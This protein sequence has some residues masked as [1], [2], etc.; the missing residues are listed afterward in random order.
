[1]HKNK[2]KQ[3]NDKHQ[4]IIVFFVC[5]KTKQNKMT[6]NANWLSSSLGAKKQKKK[7][8]RQAQLVVI[9]SQ[10]T[11]KNNKDNN[12]HQGSSSFSVANEKKGDLGKKMY[13]H[14]SKDNWSY[15]LATITPPNTIAPPSSV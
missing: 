3:D 7:Q 13:L 12:E 15:P 11:K 6:T 8:Q 1:V 14:S 9:F 2:T 4:F 10:C 5:T